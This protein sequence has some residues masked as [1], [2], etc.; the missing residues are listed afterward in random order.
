MDWGLGNPNKTAALIATLMVG[1]WFMAY[2]W[3]RGFW[4]SLM[5]FLALSVCMIH[6]FSRG[7]LIA[8]F[9]GLIPLLIYAP[10][11]W[12]WK[13]ITAV[14]ISVWVAVGFS[15]YIQ[16]NERYTKGIA[17][18][19]RSI[20]NRLKLWSAAPAMMKDAPG[21][22]GLGKSGQAYMD[23]YQPLDQHEGY[24]TMVNSHLTWLVEFGWLGRF[25]YLF[26]WTSALIIC[27]PIQRARWLSVS[28]GI[29]ISFAIA[30][31][32][33]SVG[34][35]PWL[36]ITPLTSLL[37]VLLYRWRRRVWPAPP[38]A[39]VPPSFAAVA[40]LGA[41]LAFPHTNVRKTAEGVIVGQGEPTT[42]VFVDRQVLGKQYGRTLRGNLPVSEKRTIGLVEGSDARP[43]R[44][45]S[46]QQL[47]LTGHFTTDAQLERMLQNAKEIFL[48]APRLFPQE[49]PLSAEV[50]QK[51]TILIGE[52][53][54]TPASTSWAQE[55][56]VRLLPGIG[57]FLPD[58][59]SHLLQPHEP[60]GTN[61]TAT[62]SL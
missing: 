14:L 60:V 16:A 30:A 3:R 48:V 1:V 12:P 34:E 47:I 8:A 40:V 52:F 59:P 31:T 36:W 22:W 2:I 53:S 29:W 28:F 57:D 46:I 26:G 9:A 25:L 58:W 43:K 50:L 38:L 10:R 42:W 13:R 5:L 17:Q 56:K 35:S 7:G 11:P 45:E 51:I 41:L 55:G 32:F 18:E 6:T 23:W 24:R 49:L 33:S 19:D 27:L 39:L 62:K 44:N 4:V 61:Q 54:Q 20:T 15:I 21:G 37:A